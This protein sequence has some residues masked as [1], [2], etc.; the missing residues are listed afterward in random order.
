[1]SANLDVAKLHRYVICLFVIIFFNLFYRDYNNLYTL[2]PYHYYYK[3]WIEEFSSLI[4][5]GLPKTDCCNICSVLESQIKIAVKN[6]NNNLEE[7]Y[8]QEHFKHLQ[9]A[10]NK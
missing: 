4:G 9:L 7:N 2:V 1:M 3:I 8:K 10:D 6:K 5:F